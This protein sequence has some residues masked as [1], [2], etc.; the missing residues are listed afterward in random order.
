MRTWKLVSRS[1]LYFRRTHLTVIFATALCT[2]VLVGALVV[3]DSVPHSLRRIAELRLG[4]AEHA[5]V[6][7][8][9]T[10]RGEL[11]DELSDRLGVQV[12]PV[13]NLSALAV[14]P[15]RNLRV[16]GVEVLGVDRRF[17]ALAGGEAIQT[18]EFDRSAEFDPAPVFDPGP[19]QVVIND[20]L[21]QRLDARVGEQILI[22][23]QR[24][25]VLPQEMP[26]ALER[27]EIAA[28]WVTVIGIAGDEEL[29]RFSLNANQIAPFNCF[30]SLPWLWQT[31]DA[32][33]NSDRR[34]RANILLVPE[35][36]D[37]G[38]STVRAELQGAWSL[39]D[40]G[41]TLD[42]R[43]DPHVVE[44]RSE[45][46]FLESAVSEAATAVGN[47]PT[48]VFTYLVNSLRSATGS[49]PYSFVSAAGQPIVPPDMRDDEILVNDWLAEDLR[50]SVGDE[51]VLDYY[52]LGPDQELLEESSTFS[53]REVVPIDGPAGDRDLM[54]D[55]PGLAAVES[56]LDWQPGIPIDLSRIRD[57]DERYWELFRGTPKAFVTLSAA[58]KMW[59]NRFG[60]LT[61]VRYA[62]TGEGPKASANSGNSLQAIA[63]KILNSLDPEA[64]GVRV[65]PVKEQGLK[66]GT[67]AVDFGQL[68]LGLSVF[69]LGAAILLTTLLYTL[70]VEQRSE[71][72]GL[73]RALGFSRR[74]IRRIRLT[75]GSLLALLG[76][77]VGTGLGILYNQVLLRGL[78]TVWRGAVGVSSL[79]LQV[80]A[81]TLLIGG[82]SGLIISVATMW[83]ISARQAV[84]PPSELQRSSG[85][86]QRDSSRRTIRLLL[87]I[88][89][90]LI[91]G[92][93]IA[94]A[95]IGI[96]QE[97]NPTGTFFL[98]GG[99]LLVGTLL[100]G[101]YVLASTQK[102]AD[103]TRLS[104]LR[105]GLRSVA[106]RPKRSAAV[107]GLF[108]FG[109]FIVFAVGANRI[110]L[111]IDPDDRESGTGGFVLYGE[112]TMPIVQDLNDP[113]DRNRI[114]FPRTGF[115]Q[116][117]FVQLRVHEGEDASCLNLNQ[118]R[119]PRVLGVPP[120]EFARRGSFSFVSHPVLEAGENPWQLLERGIDANTIPA[121]VDQSVLT[122]G[123]HKSIGDTL[124]YTDERGGEFKLQLMGS[125]ENSVFQGSVLIS[126]R[127]F[128]EHFPSSSG[129]Q[130]LLV[131]AP[132]NQSEQVSERV[133]RALRDYGLELLPAAVRL[134]EFNRVQNTYLSI[135]LLLGGLGLVLGSFGMGLVVARNVLERRGELALLRAVGIGRRM[136]QRILLSE[137]LLMLGFGLAS[138]LISAVVAVLPVVLH[139]GARLPLPFLGVLLVA[140]A[141]NGC[142]WTWL[143]VVATTR[144]D[145]L[146]A[147]RN[148]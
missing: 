15:E 41:L 25:E 102:S 23:L 80:K 147:L 71:E 30:L 148:E 109:I 141:G 69:L 101:S 128:I 33:D 59:E 133:Q 131:D 27:T 124:T 76:C 5:L 52:V 104:V 13:L 56:S 37:K 115:D 122:W 135:F 38:A 24:P 32:A 113:V 45:R 62:A 142:L 16:G 100:L 67:G 143:S 64:V 127:G 79:E 12:A 11:A 75:E 73:L 96:R 146:P 99:I 20:R 22:R 82:L 8:T 119:N 114:G 81:L 6:S 31:I 144:G 7:S 132:T 60:N 121:V 126:E 92:T 28:V 35:G 91:T 58:Q 125:L 66:A 36:T 68:F 42:L 105:V 110:G 26:F 19:G 93:G 48:G 123:L 10:F 112:T 83:I 57:K 77:L 49:T 107:A 61:A 117:S 108:A 47:Q 85:S 53:V 111:F 116:V 86:I 118:V 40:A 103:K 65:V 3:G 54:P 63:R 78:D 29:G 87:L 94:L 95:A 17:W 106:R 120:D 130:V 46:V 2:A 98:A 129:T 137:H 55:F 84:R 90:M 134:G 89:G 14:V 50:L 70:G 1:L 139:Q 43:S 9:R 51:L 18:R 44:L 145:P 39:A 97:G 136:L 72:T 34:P 21:A 88:A 138:G 4:A 74:R 140:V